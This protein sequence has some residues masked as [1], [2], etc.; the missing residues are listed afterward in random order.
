[1]GPLCANR[2]FSNQIQGVT[3]SWM[4][5]DFIARTFCC[6]LSAKLECRHSRPQLPHGFLL[7][8]SPVMYVNEPKGYRCQF[9]CEEN[10][11]VKRMEGKTAKYPVGKNTTQ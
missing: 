6:Q 1:M 7:L 2:I 4:S 5:A 3:I 8:Y 9:A 11:V 10:R